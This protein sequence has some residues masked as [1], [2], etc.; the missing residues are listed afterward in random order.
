MPFPY[1][2]AAAV[3]FDGDFAV[4][5]PPG[6]QATHSEQDLSR[7]VRN[8]LDDLAAIAIDPARL[9]DHR[10]N[11]ER[12]GL[13]DGLRSLL[14]GVSDDVV[15]SEQALL[16]SYELWGKFDEIR[17]QIGQCR[18]HV[19][20]LDSQGRI[21]HGRVGFEDILYQ[22]GK[23]EPTADQIAL[24]SAIDRALSVVRKV[25]QPSDTERARDRSDY[26]RALVG[27]ASAGLEY[28]QAPLANGELATFRQ[29]FVT[30]EASALKN[31]YVRRLG[32]WAVFLAGLVLACFLAIDWNYVDYA[33]PRFNDRYG[34]LAHFEPYL[35]RY[36][37]LLLVATGA[38]GGAWLA[39]LIR[40][41]TLAFED[42]TQLDEDLLTPG[43]RMTYT[44][45]LSP[46]VGLLFWTGMVSISV[47]R[48]NTDS[49]ARSGLVCLVVGA[50]S[51]IA[52]RGVATAVGRRADD[53]AAAIGGTARPSP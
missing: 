11:G 39:F 36:Q 37:N 49:L 22:F 29:D 1:T 42:L 31:G 26:I 34:F 9:A 23:G 48:F 43:V 30:R 51:G 24:K 4:T 10:L 47:G 5:L 15:T 19:G 41:P 12:K 8:V 38:A 35:H 14:H 7:R 27:I 2:I 32:L 21:L 25:V 33:T 18:F 16:D 20:G 6:A 53:F 44:M 52:S 40:R 45:L 13:A 17:S 50:L 46:L 3:R 28:G